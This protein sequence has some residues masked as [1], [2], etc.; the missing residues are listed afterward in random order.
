M[1]RHLFTFLIAF[2]LASAQDIPTSTAGSSPC[3]LQCV[4]QSLSAG[5]CANPVD[6]T[7]LCTSGPYQAAV[8]SC[9]Q[10]NCSSGDMQSALGLQAQQCGAA[11]LSVT[12]GASSTAPPTT[13]SS[14]SGGGTTGSG[15]S[16]TVLTNPSGS[17]PSPP[18]TTLSS[19]STGPGLPSTSSSPS[20]TDSG[21]SGGQ[22][23]TQNAAPPTGGAL[24]FVHDIIAIAVVWAG[25][26]VGGVMIL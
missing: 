14:G 26:V 3:I 9:L 18:S 10:A 24:F 17:E 16:T 4:Q 15:S 2:G 13:A 23:Q 22:S 8:R 25:V 1:H 11:G 19:V 20:N 6:I 7:C 21:S 5:G 12:S